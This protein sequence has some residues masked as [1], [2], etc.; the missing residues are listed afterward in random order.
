MILRISWISLKIRLIFTSRNQKAET[1]RQV[2]WR[3][4]TNF[5]SHT[6]LSSINPANCL[7]SAESLTN[8]PTEWILSSQIA[9]MTWQTKPSDGICQVSALKTTR[10]AYQAWQIFPKSEFCQVRLRK[11]W[12]IFLSWSF[13]QVRDVIC[14]SFQR[15]CCQNDKQGRVCAVICLSFQRVCCQNDK[16]NRVRAV[17]CLSFQR[18]CCQNDKQNRVSTVICLSFQRVCCQNDKQGRVCAVICLSYRRVNVEN[19]KQK[20]VRTN[21]D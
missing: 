15:V 18:V 11:T 1:T 8:I 16:H 6:N 19:D 14:L 21:S 7:E 9:K 12:Q 20:D 17:I 2:K 13:C 3:N 5:K 4:L 10:R